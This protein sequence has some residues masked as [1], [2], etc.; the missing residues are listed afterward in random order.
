[1]QQNFELSDTYVKLKKT[2]T[3]WLSIIIETALITVLVYMIIMPVAKKFNK[4]K[5]DTKLIR[6]LYFKR[7]KKSDDPL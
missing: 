6:K 4:L 2:E 3:G 5:F 7:N 1:M